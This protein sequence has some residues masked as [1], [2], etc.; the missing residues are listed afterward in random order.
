MNGTF[1]FRPVTLDDLSGLADLVGN[2]AGGLTTLS[3]DPRFL[4]NKVHASERAFYPHIEKPG[5]EH[6]LFVLENTETGQIVGTSGIISQV[7]GFDP[8]YTYEIRKQPQ[9]YAPLQISREVRALH[10]N[11]SHRGPSEICSLFLHPLCRRGGLG[12]LLSLSRFLFMHRFPERFQ[13]DVI[14]EMRGYLDPSGTSPFWEAV[15]HFFF[16]RDYSSADV[17]SGLGEKGFIE[18]LMPKYPIYVDLL[19]KPA[20]DVLGKVHR[21]TEPALQLLLREGFKHTS[22]ID[23]FDAG[24]VVRAP[25]RELR[26]VQRMR[27]A[28]LSPTLSADAELRSNVLITNRAL[29]FRA[30]LTFARVTKEG[31][32]S[33]EPEVARH[34][35][36]EAGAIVDFCFL[37]S[38]G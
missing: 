30:M 15:G 20:R 17:L 33:V 19:P 27:S 31:A 18:A 14:A 6:Y 34:L 3:N 23:I 16:R 37:H 38:E 22:E 13:E 2:I 4:E 1:V 9:F 24:P 32:L 10:L 5:G 28:P 12:K 11:R 21:D 7:G 36:I 35:Q 29:D 26:T 25:V 8:F